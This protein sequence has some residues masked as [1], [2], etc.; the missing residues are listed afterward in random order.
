MASCSVGA[1][2]PA[3]VKKILISVGEMASCSL[4]SMALVRAE[5]NAGYM[6]VGAS[7][8]ALLI[9]R[10]AALCSAGSALLMPSELKKMSTTAWGLSAA[11]V[12][13]WCA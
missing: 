8:M 12:Q 6:V 3:G 2:V 10:L 7:A 4:W 11:S 13:Q 5:C 1:L 9:A